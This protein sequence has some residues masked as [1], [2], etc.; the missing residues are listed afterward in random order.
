MCWNINFKVYNSQHFI[1]LKYIHFRKHI[2]SAGHCFLGEFA[3]QKVFA[4]LW[5]D[6]ELNIH[7]EQMKIKE[8]IQIKV[9]DGLTMEILAEE[10]DDDIAILTL[11]IP[12]V[13]SSEVHIKSIRI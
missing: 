8:V 9:Y 5:R 11:K 4:V 1:L 2:L 6:T 10:R 12:L 13:F 3:P 7:K